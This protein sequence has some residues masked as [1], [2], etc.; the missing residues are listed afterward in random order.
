MSKKRLN[1]PSFMYLVTIHVAGFKMNM[2]R[3]I[4]TGYRK[5]K[6]MCQFSIFRMINYGSFHNV[7]E[8]DRRNFLWVSFFH[9]K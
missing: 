8:P 5:I 6:D 2:C 3:T 7:Y 1:L 9:E 4:K